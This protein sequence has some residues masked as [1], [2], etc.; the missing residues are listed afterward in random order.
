MHHCENGEN[1]KTTSSH[2][3]NVG[4]LLKHKNSNKLQSTDFLAFVSENVHLLLIILSSYLIVILISFLFFKL[5]LSNR[6][7]LSKK[8]LAVLELFF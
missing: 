6:T 4:Q 7:F 5:F 1:S 2:G 8:S 3:Y